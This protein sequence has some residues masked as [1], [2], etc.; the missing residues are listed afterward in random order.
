M[1]F[2]NNRGIPF[3]IMAGED[4]MNAGVFTVKNMESGEQERLTVEQM[5]ERLSLSKKM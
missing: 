4:E 1:T 2:A 3:V 5:V